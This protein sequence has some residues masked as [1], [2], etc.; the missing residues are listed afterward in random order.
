MLRLRDTVR[1][2]RAASPSWC[3]SPSSPSSPPLQRSG[4]LAV[5]RTDR[6]K[7][8]VASPSNPPDLAVQPA[9]RLPVRAEQ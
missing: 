9:G 5:E 6:E 1:S 3:S 2:S 8:P 4:R 7:P